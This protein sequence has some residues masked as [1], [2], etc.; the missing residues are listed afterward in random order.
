[1]NCIKFIRNI[2]WIEPRCDHRRISLPEIP[3]LGSTARR[4]TH[5]FFFPATSLIS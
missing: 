4:E 5:S 1:M 3:L 2:L